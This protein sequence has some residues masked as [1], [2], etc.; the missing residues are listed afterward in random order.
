M[1]TSKDVFLTIGKGTYCI[2]TPLEEGTLERVNEL[3]NQACGSLV[4]GMGQEEVLALTCLRLA[5]SLDRTAE[6]LKGL[7]ERLEGNQEGT[8]GP[9]E[10]E[11]L[12]L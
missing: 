7:L 12:L 1:A 6:G 2:K 3:V 11:T 5:Y 9:E 4:R 10:D 8:M